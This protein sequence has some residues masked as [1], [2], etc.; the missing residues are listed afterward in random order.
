M[1]FRGHEHELVSV[2]FL[3]NHYPQRSSFLLASAFLYV[4]L[5]KNSSFP[6]RNSGVNDNI[7]HFLTILH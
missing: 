6:T 2:W 5:I 1:F 4:F 7:M 3:L